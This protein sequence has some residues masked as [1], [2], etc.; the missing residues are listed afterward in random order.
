[1]QSNMTN[2]YEKFKRNQY[3]KRYFEL[4]NKE[5]L[6]RKELNTLENYGR[7]IAEWDREK[8]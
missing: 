4:N 1:M 3:R 2:E 5:G 8:E 7:Y 6:T